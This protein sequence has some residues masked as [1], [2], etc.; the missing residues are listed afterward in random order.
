V[1]GISPKDQTSFRFLH[2]TQPHRNGTPQAFQLPTTLCYARLYFGRPFPFT[3]ASFA[4]FLDSHS[5]LLLL[6]S[7][8]NH[9]DYPRHGQ[10]RESSTSTRQPI[11]PSLLSSSLIPRSRNQ[12]HSS[13]GSLHSYPRLESC[14]REVP[15]D[16]QDPQL[17]LSVGRRMESLYGGPQLDSI[18]SCIRKP[19]RLLL[20]LD[21]WSF[22][23]HRSFPRSL[24]KMEEFV[25]SRSRPRR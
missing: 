22:R 23:S 9:S 5:R 1:N 6:P 19:P 3:F 25:L 4:P 18:A 20:Y 2:F 11:P 12:Q 17:S 7:S 16:P 24:R 14:S 15:R 8:R 13:T 21:Q 10:R